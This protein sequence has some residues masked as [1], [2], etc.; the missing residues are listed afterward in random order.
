MNSFQGK[1]EC[2]EIVVLRSI[3]MFFWV[4]KCHCDIIYHLNVLDVF[5]IEVVIYEISSHAI[6]VIEILCMKSD[7]QEH[8]DIKLIIVLL[9]TVAITVIWKL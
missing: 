9:F 3:L 4:C 1:W 2:I 6:N 8:I 5:F 7:K